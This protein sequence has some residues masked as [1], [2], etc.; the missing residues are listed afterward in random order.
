MSAV[1]V[2]FLSRNHI[3]GYVKE[4]INKLNQRQLL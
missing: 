1:F 2:T 4:M 3:V